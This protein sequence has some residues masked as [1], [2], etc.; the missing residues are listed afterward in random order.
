MGSEAAYGAPG[1][2]CALLVGVIGKAAP[3]SFHEA[4]VG[5]SITVR[6]SRHG[7]AGMSIWSR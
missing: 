1:V 6:T 5:L 3:P 4:R 7:P 2:L